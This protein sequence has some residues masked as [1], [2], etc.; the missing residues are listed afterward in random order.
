MDYDK[1]ILV[2]YGSVQ[3]INIDIIDEKIKMIIIIDDNQNKL[4]TDLIQRTQ[5][6][7]NSIEWVQIKKDGKKNTLKIFIAYLLGYY[8]SDQS[9]KEFKICS[10]SKDYD[11]LIKYL[12]NKNINVE[13]MTS[14]KQISK[15][16]KNGFIKK[17]LEHILMLFGKWK[18]IGKICFAVIV[19]AVIGAIIVLLSSTT[20]VPVIDVPIRNEAALGRI[21][22]RINREGVKISVTAD[23]LVQVSNEITARRMRGIIIREDLIFTEFDPW[24]IFERESET[25]TD[26]ELN[27]KVQRA[28]NRMLADLIKTFDDVDEAIVTVVRPNTELLGMDENPGPSAS[29]IITPKPGSDITKNRKKI[30]YIQKILKL[31]VESLKDENIVIVDQNGLLLNDFVFITE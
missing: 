31:G 14:F 16:N 19:F 21:V 27:V 13:R 25:I 5:P 4:S 10:N 17:L 18:Q 26:F 8:I 28:Q 2:D 9:N 15:D 1:Y 3:D 30:E 11:L 24:T 7:G 23:G 12:K 22:S 29:V 6:F 20:M